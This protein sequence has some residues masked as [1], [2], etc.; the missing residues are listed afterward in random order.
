[1][2]EKKKN[3]IEKYVV[4]LFLTLFYE[5]EIAEFNSKDSQFYLQ[6]TIA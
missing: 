1:M 4:I 6:V 3:K 5:V 2:F